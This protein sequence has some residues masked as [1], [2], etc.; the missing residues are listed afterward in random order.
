MRNSHVGARPLAVAI[1]ASLVVLPAV[2]PLAAGAGGT[3]VSLVPADDSVKI[4]ETT[5]VQVVV[6]NAD[7]GAGSAEFRVAV[8][9]ADTARV[10]D[11]TVLGSGQV[12]K[13][14]ADD[15]SWIDVEYAFVDTADTGN[16]VIAE[17][18][19]EGVSDG[20]AD[21]SLE[22][23]AGDDA[24]D[25]YDEAG[26]GYSVTGTNGA[27]LAVGVS[28]TE[29]TAD[30][31]SGRATEDRGSSGDASDSDAGDDTDDSSDTSLSDS[32]DA[33]GD[34]ASSGSEV[35]DDVD[36]SPRLD[37]E[38]TPSN[39]AVSP[40]PEQSNDVEESTKFGITLGI[41]TLDRAAGAVGGPVGVAVAAV[42]LLIGIGIGRR[43]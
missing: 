22:P 26:T 38:G 31:G 36:D 23:A 37:D 42:V 33:S 41:A 14:V 7:G 12:E 43:I 16:V 3:T 20:T 11:A 2:A 13:R 30:A 32:G 21:V 10:V 40:A 35:E 28:E 6:D 15:G 24:M 9:D 27:Q 17:V 5:T 18:I 34:D 29:P 25:V 1:V 8:D 4:D 19:V 39:E